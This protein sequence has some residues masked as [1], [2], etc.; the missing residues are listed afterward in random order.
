MRNYRTE[1]LVVHDVLGFRRKLHDPH[2]HQHSHRVDD[3]TAIRQQHGRSRDPGPVS[4]N[5]RAAVVI[6]RN[7]RATDTADA[8]GRKCTRFE[9]HAIPL[10][11]VREPRRNST[12]KVTTYEDLRR[13]HFFFFYYEIPF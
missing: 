11:S 2:E 13:F 1:D 3:R 8:P 7:F 6:Q 9:P 4:R 5:R 12:L 10:R